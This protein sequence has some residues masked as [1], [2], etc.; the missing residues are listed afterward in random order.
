VAE[1]ASFEYVDAGGRNVR[2]ARLTAPADFDEGFD[3]IEFADGKGRDRQRQ[4]KSD[5]NTDLQ[6]TQPYSDENA[7][8]YLLLAAGSRPSRLIW[9]DKPDVQVDFSDGS[10]VFVEAAE[11]IEEPSAHFAGVLRYINVGIRKA[12]QGN[13]AVAHTV[14]IRASARDDDRYNAKAILADSLRLFERTNAPSTS[15]EFDEVGGDYPALQSVKARFRL[16]DVPILPYIEMEGSGGTGESTVSRTRDILEQK[17]ELAAT[18]TVRPLW[19]ALYI[20]DPDTV[21]FLA[22]D[23]LSEVE[24][25][26][27]PYLRLFVGNQQD[28]MVYSVET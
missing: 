7:V 4:Y 17:R 23:A 11:I 2:A 20:S 18:Y 27:S 10:T 16:L 15:Q 9:R 1:R 26:F 5:P 28:V 21:P 3:E 8:A 19:L 22:V 6:F 24:L 14:E 12:L 25:D 13:P